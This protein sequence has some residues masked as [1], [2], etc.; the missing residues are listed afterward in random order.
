M[1]FVMAGNLTAIDAASGTH[2]WSFGPIYPGKSSPAVSIDGGTVFVG[3][4]LMTVVYKRVG[5]LLAID[6]ATGMQIWSWEP[7]ARWSGGMA[8]YTGVESSPVVSPNGRVVF[9]V[10][11]DCN[12]SAINAASGRQ[13]WSLKPGGA[14]SCSNP[15]LFADPA[16]SP[17]VSPDSTTVFVGSHSD[18]SKK[19]NMHA[20]DAASGRQV[21]SFETKQDLMLHLSPT[22]SPDGGT[23]FVKGH[24]DMSFI[25]GG[26]VRRQNCMR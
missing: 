12:V 15:T 22:V 11:S 4:R 24:W 5:C 17:A 1:F 20:I 26:G 7:T 10:L 16:F 18:D 8:Q 19:S 25:G 14:Q 2:I 13:I 23:V 3:T 9:V 21:W 6:A